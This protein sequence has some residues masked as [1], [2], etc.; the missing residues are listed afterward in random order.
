MPSIW[1]CGVPARG[2]TGS[3]FAHRGTG[4]AAMSAANRKNRFG[5]TI[6]YVRIRG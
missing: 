6:V 3:G 1:A 5:A 4:A 2:A